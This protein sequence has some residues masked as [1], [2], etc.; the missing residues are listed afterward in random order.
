MADIADDIMLCPQFVVPDID[1]G[2]AMA[3]ESSRS[4][5]KRHPEGDRLG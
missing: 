1:A 4:L 2:F 5:V 3:G